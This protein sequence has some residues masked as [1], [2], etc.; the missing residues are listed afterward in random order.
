MWKQLLCF[1]SNANGHKMES[2]DWG[3]AIK[4][5]SDIYDTGHEVDNWGLDGSYLYRC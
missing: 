5:E 4:W 2:E 1:Q 3:V